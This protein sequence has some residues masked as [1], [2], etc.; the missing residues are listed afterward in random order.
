MQLD[1]LVH[2]VCS[3]YLPWI[4]NYNTACTVEPVCKGFPTIKDQKT[5]VMSLLATLYLQQDLPSD[6]MIYALIT[7]FGIILNSK[8][9]NFPIK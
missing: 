6:C 9:Q 5:N 8:I 1:E 2:Y 7:M 4:H 3:N